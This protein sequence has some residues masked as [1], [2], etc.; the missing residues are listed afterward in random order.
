MAKTEHTPTPQSWTLRPLRE[1]YHE[2]LNLDSGIQKVIATVR[3][4][5]NAELIIQAANCHDDLLRACENL[6][7]YANDYSDAMAENGRGA[8]QLGKRADCI[9]VAGMAKAAIAK[10]KKT[11]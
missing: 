4:K 10:A 7:N 8:A 9:S 11:S 1:D 6:L 3:Y 2:I 5:G